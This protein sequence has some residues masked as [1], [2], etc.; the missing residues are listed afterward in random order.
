MIETDTEVK[1]AVHRFSRLHNY[2]GV[3]PWRKFPAPWTVAPQHLRQDWQSGQL[4]W[5]LARAHTG[6]NRGQIPP[7]PSADV[8]AITAH[9]L[10]WHKVYKAVL[11]TCLAL[12]EI[13]SEGHDS[14][15]KVSKNT[16]AQTQ[17]DN[18]NDLSSLGSSHRLNKNAKMFSRPSH[19][20]S[21]A[22]FI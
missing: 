22:R 20:F 16:S 3:R 21:H 11:T 17:C 12:L 7:P 9:A 10:A 1:R 19:T 5:C 8:T 18:P 13:P 2:W 14:Q 6:I 15:P 4:Q